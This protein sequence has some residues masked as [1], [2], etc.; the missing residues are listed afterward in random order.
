MEWSTL[1]TR[2][3][4]YIP[5]LQWLPYY[6]RRQFMGDLLAGLSLSSLFIPQALS[7]SIG[8]CRLPAKHGLYTISIPT[9]IYACLGM[10]P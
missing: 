7:Y 8:L 9:L 5:M 6:N 2:L 1:K 4:Y 3:I 10:S